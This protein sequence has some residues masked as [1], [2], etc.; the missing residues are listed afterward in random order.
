MNSNDFTGDNKP[1]ITKY[2]DMLKTTTDYE[3]ID[4][5][6]K[7]LEKRKSDRKEKRARDNRIRAR[8]MKAGAAAL[9]LCAGYGLHSLA[10]LAKPYL[11]AVS[12][13][14]KESTEMAR[15]MEEYSKTEEGYKLGLGLQY[16]EAGFGGPMVVDKDSEK[17]VTVIDGKKVGAYP[18]YLEALNRYYE[19]HSKDGNNYYESLNKQNEIL[20]MFG[21]KPVDSIYTDEEIAALANDNIDSFSMGG[22]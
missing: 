5:D 4:I 11:K 8:R 19:S 3:H 7:E 15:I 6:Y 13:Y 20:K 18:D 2:S 17:N 9:I 22:L 12:D 14:E 1:D 16:R 21:L 10:D